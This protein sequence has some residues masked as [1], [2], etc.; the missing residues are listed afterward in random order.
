MREFTFIYEKLRWTGLGKV[1]FLWTGVI[2]WTVYSSVQFSSV[3]FKVQDRYT[4]GKFMSSGKLGR[5]AWIY[6]C[7]IICAHFI[8][9][10]TVPISDPVTVSKGLFNSLTRS[11]DAIPTYSELLSHVRTPWRIFYTTR[12]ALRSAII[13]D[14]SWCMQ[15]LFN[16]PRVKLRTT[17][18]STI[19]V[20][21][22]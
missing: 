19:I 22:L 11:T 14:A 12:T 5:R 1:W 20:R 7:T 18:P 4:D 17:H 2:F 13:R 16:L 15:G 10:T 8:H 21:L 6:V 9:K 3:Q